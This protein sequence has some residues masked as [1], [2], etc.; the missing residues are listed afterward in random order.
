MQVKKL[1]TSQLRKLL[2]Q[3]GLSAKPFKLKGFFLFS[4]KL[5]SFYQQ[6]L[7]NWPRFESE[8]FWNSEMAYWPLASLWY[9]ISILGANKPHF[10]RIV[11]RLASFWNWGGLDHENCLFN[12]KR[13]PS[14]LIKYS[15]WEPSRASAPCAL[16]T[17]A[18]KFQRICGSAGE[19]FVHIFVSLVWIDL[20][21][22]CL[23]L[24]SL[25][26]TPD[27]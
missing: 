11:L 2:F 1:A 18:F 10:T 12:D 16:G 25:K 13:I 14:W 23:S 8:G 9:W 15:H 21:S 22:C 19:L 20:F 27:T 7:C 4:C 5:N 3:S 6:R 24:F 17:R 26:R